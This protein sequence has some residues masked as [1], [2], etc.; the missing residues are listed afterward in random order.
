MLTSAALSVLDVRT[1]ERVERSDIDSRILV[2]NNFYTDTQQHRHRNR[3][4][5]VE[6]DRTDG[7]DRT[8]GTVA[9]SFATYKGKLF[10]LVSRYS[11]PRLSRLIG[12][13]IITDRSD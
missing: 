5:P 3:P 4:L 7:A 9:G 12:L 6:A 11:L 13:V 10:F 8:L 2:Q 1:M